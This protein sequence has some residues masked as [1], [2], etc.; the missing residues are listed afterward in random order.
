MQYLRIPLPVLL[1]STLPLASAATAQTVQNQY[2]ILGASDAQVNDEFSSGMDLYGNILV[3]G[4]HRADIGPDATNADQGVVYVYRYDGTVWVEEAILRSSGPGISDEFGSAVAVHENRFVGGSPLN[5][6]TPSGDEGGAYVFEYDGTSWT[7]TG[8]LVASDG[9]LGDQLGQSVAIEGDFVFCSAIFNDAPVTTLG[10]EGAVY[11][12]EYDGSSWSQSQKLVASDAEET[13]EFGSSI[14]VNG[15]R[16]IV[17][18]NKENEAALTAAG[19]VYVFDYDGTNW[20]ETAKIVPSLRHNGQSFG[21][22]VDIEGDRIVV[23]ADENDTLGGTTRAGALWIYEFDGINWNEV[24]KLEASD[25]QMDD[26]LG[27]G[28]A[29]QGDFIVGGAIGEDSADTNGGAAYLF[30]YDGAT[31]NEIAKLVGTVSGISDTL[32]RNVNV[33]GDF[34]LANSR[35]A[36]TGVGSNVGGVFIFNASVNATAEHAEFVASKLEGQNPLV[37]DFTDASVGGTTSWSWDFGD[38]FTSTAQHPTHTYF[39]FGT[40]DVSLAVTGPLGSDSI[41]KTGLIVADPLL[42]SA[43]VRNGNGTNPLCYQ[44]VSLP[45]LGGTFTTTIDA[46]GH[47]GAGLTVVLGYDL[48]FVGAPT[49]FGELLIGVEALGG[50]FAYGTV[51][52]SG[53]GVA[54]HSSA[55]PTDVSFIG[56]SLATQGIILGGAGPEL[57]NAID[58]VMGW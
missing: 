15:T 9:A 19:A 13:E 53:G 37:V 55:A 23:G 16:L 35:V 33:Q 39:N 18:C 27:T 47:P 29:L 56:I 54:T 48:P 31:W 21:A 5:N 57:C 30:E 12:F 28:C 26:L 43:I 4:S 11:V 24:A 2:F 40:F 44:P 52:D 3:S 25:A 51:V 34:V 1:L 22:S 6:L 46:S 8:E 14:A 58:L 7:E 50:V 38:G 45:I 41:T 36:R 49:P 17:G 10:D 42:A 32:G 20:L